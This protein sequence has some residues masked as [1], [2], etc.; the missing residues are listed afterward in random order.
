MSWSLCKITKHQVQEHII[1]KATN[2]SS[3]IVCHYF[4]C[5]AFHITDCYTSL[6][7]NCGWMAFGSY[8]FWAG[9]RNWKCQ[10]RI[11]TYSYIQYSMTLHLSSTQIA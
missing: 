3:S 7:P 10:A 2:L 4:Q 11:H 9:N 5:T 8:W 6:C 1:I